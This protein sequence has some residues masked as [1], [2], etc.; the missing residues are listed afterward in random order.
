MEA[1]RNYVEALFATLPQDVD[2]LRI[3]AD[4]LGNLEE[5]YHALLDDG[6]NEA[7]ATGIVIASIGSAEDL[8]EEFGITDAP[9]QTAPTPRSNVT[10]PILPVLRR[11]NWLVI[12]LIYL[13]WAAAMITVTY[14]VGELTSYDRFIP[15]YSWTT[16]LML[17]CIAGGVRL[18]YALCVRY[19]IAIRFYALSSAIAL[20]ITACAYFY[21]GHY[22]GLWRATWTYFPAII[23]LLI[24]T[25]WLERSK[26]EN[27]ATDEACRSRICIS[28][29]N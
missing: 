25:A 1:I 18:G 5:K 15:Y 10:Q 26:T 23:I 13:I 7:E 20:P 3:K 6:K 14:I 28:E 17:V 8:R 22:W 27:V 19:Q 4:M 21:L 2:T 24:G 29:K 11:Q 16:F 9:V 12:G